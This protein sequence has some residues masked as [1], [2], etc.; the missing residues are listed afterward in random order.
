MSELKIEEGTALTMAAGSILGITLGQQAV[1]AFDHFAEATA[2]AYMRP[3]AV[4]VLRTRRDSLKQLTS[5]KKD[6]MKAAGTFNKK[7]ARVLVL[8][9]IGESCRAVA[10]LC[11]NEAKELEARDQTGSADE[12]GAWSK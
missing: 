1:S 9:L 11:D 10:D 5:K 4:E 3:E 2:A 7:T 8:R 6:E 12:L